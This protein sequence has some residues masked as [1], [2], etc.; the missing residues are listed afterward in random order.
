MSRKRQWERGV[1]TVEMIR[2][3]KALSGYETAE[4]DVDRRMSVL[5]SGNNII[6]R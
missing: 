1:A 4:K 3:I 6:T 2:D 5:L